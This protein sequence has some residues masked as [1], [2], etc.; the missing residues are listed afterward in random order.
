MLCSRFHVD[1]VINILKFFKLGNNSW[2]EKC[3]Q[4]SGLR[5]QAQRGYPQLAVSLSDSTQMQPLDSVAKAPT[6]FETRT[7]IPVLTG[8]SHSGDNSTG[9]IFLLRDSFIGSNALSSHGRGRLIQS[10]TIMAL[11]R[12]ATP[13]QL[14]RSANAKLWHW[15]TRVRSSSG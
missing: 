7:T 2:K 12:C 3:A 5:S 4:H 13:S 8:A 6:Q 15:V 14:G 9:S 10:E 11:R 1:A